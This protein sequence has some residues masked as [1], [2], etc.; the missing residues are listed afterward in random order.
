MPEFMNL[1]FVLIGAGTWS[2]DAMLERRRMMK[3]VT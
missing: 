2:V 1:P 3:P